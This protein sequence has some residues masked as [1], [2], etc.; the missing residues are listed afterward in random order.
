MELI[1]NNPEQ[2][3]KSE[4]A[5]EKHL[6][7]KAYISYTISPPWGDEYARFYIKLPTERCLAPTLHDDTMLTLESLCKKCKENNKQR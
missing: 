4:C 1:C 3:E 2:I 5:V 7:T 6:A